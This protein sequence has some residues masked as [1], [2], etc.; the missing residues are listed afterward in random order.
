MN[1]G[2]TPKLFSIQDVHDAAGHT[3]FQSL[4]IH[5]HRSRAIDAC[6]ATLVRVLGLR[7]LYESHRL[8]QRPTLRG[9][10]EEFPRLRSNTRDAD[11]LRRTSPYPSWR[12]P[13][14]YVTLTVI[15]LLPESGSRSACSP[16]GRVYSV[17]PASVVPPV[18][19]CGRT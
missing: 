4:Q 9:R 6:T 16:F 7:R 13:T 11:R 19:P 5:S 10:C 12:E 17:M 8:M 15:V 1:Q 18:T 14:R 2:F 3:D